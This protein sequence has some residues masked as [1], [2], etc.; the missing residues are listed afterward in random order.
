MKPDYPA[1]SPYVTSVGG[2]MLHHGNVAPNNSVDRG[3]MKYVLFILSPTYLPT[4]ASLI[5][6]VYFNDYTNVKTFPKNPIP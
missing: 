2:T 1:S 4:V 6:S 5:L 3:S